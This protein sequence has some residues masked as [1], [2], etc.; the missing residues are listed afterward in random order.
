MNIDSREG[1]PVLFTFFGRVYSKSHFSWIAVLPELP[2]ILLALR[3]QE[4]IIRDTCF[5]PRTPR[6]YLGGELFGQ[7][8]PYFALRS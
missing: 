3:T 7:D 8:L 5:F 6:N 2:I 4:G 1:N